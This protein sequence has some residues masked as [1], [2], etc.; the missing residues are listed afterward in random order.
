VHEGHEHPDFLQLRLRLLPVQ[1]GQLQFAGW[2]PVHAAHE[3][4]VLCTAA[5]LLRVKARELEAGAVKA[6]TLT[7]QSHRARVTAEKCILNLFVY[8]T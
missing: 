5:M 1:A 2:R 6:E 3:Q 7:A 8:F 4:A